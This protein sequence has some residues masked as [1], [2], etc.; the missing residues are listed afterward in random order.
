MLS[1]LK[2]A[3]CCALCIL[4]I[5]ILSFRKPAAVFITQQGK[6]S[7]VSN[8]PLEVIRASSDKLQGA[9]NADNRSFVFK[10][11]ITSF[12]G[13]NS[14]LQ[15]THFN[16]NYMESDRFP[17]ATFKGRIIEQVNLTEPGNYDIRAKGKLTIHG[18]EQERIIKAS[19]KSD[20][21]KL[22]VS[23]D[24]NVP[25]ADHD[26]TIPKIVYQKIASDIEVKI[27][28]DFELTKN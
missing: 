10:V 4:T 1:S 5:F 17:E 21:T 3:L 12:K 22:K 24:F 14:A 25:L 8:A 26:I 16:E 19:V 9:I 18:V 13:F 28:A 27:E 6:V 7:F 11:A 15:R 20:G 23:A 2:Y